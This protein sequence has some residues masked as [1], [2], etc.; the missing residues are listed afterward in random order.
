VNQYVRMV[1]LKDKK[2]V[3]IL[4]DDFPSAVYLKTIL[5][6]NNYEIVDIVDTGERAIQICKIMK[7]D[8]ILVDIMLA[9]RLTGSEAAVH[10]NHDTP[11]CKVIF[12]TAYAEEDMIED[13]VMSHAFAYLMKP[14]RAKEIL[15]TMRLAL[16]NH[17]HSK[18]STTVPLINGFIFNTQEH[19]LYK[20]SNEIPLSG[21]KLKLIEF[22]VKNKN[23]SISN[24]QISHVLWGEN[25]S[26]STLRSL[27]HR[28]REA[29]GSDIIENIKGVGY[30][31][32]SK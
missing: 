14:Y 9:G 16:S 19:R 31:L 7:P 25:K 5:L 21:K 8:I 24:T 30:K 29:L 23:S 15:A 6:K 17:N 4:E 3:L 27:I 26:T 22:L 1:I 12:L 2:R 28:V 11:E 20:D 32:Y 13:A 18:K 10:I